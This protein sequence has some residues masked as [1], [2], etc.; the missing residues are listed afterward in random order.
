[1]D[2]KQAENALKVFMTKMRE[3]E[4]DFADLRKKYEKA[5]TEEEKLKVLVDAA[6]TQ[7]DL[8]QL[9]PDDV[10]PNAVITVTVTVTITYAPSAY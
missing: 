10:D 6:T 2:K 8:Q 3:N 9:L 5:K 1:M 4:A 7:G